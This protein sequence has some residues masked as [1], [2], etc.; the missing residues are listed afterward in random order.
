V[1]MVL[2]VKMVLLVQ[3]DLPDLLDP[4]DLPDPLVQVLTV[5]M[6]P[7]EHLVLMVPQE[8]MD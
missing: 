2:P 6:E 4:L 7:L 1:Q 5:K 8:K 3:M